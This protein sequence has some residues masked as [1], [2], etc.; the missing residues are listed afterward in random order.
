MSNKNEM[1]SDALKVYEEAAKNMTVIGKC[2]CGEPIYYFLAE[3]PEN[4]YLYF[5][6]G[7]GS[8]GDVRFAKHG[9][10]FY[11]NKD[12][13]DSPLL[14]I[15]SDMYKDFKSIHHSNLFNDNVNSENPTSLVWDS[16]SSNSID[17]TN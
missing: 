13:E 17:Y 9:D 12:S 4:F 8:V 2:K 5:C 3:K 6:F 10:M 1:D 7:C 11:V 15:I 14:S 16:K